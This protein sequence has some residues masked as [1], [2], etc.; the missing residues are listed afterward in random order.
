MQR[1]ITKSE[2]MFM[3]FFFSEQSTVLSGLSCLRLLQT[4]TWRIIAG[5]SFSQ[6]FQAKCGWE[7]LELFVMVNNTSGHVLSVTSEPQHA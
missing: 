7:D 3:A 5:S 4:L 2:C 6:A 1:W